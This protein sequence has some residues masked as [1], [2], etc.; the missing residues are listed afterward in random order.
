[1]DFAFLCV[2]FA[3]ATDIPIIDPQ[4]DSPQLIIE[5]RGTLDL[6]T[7]LDRLRCRQR[8]RRQ[9]T[10]KQIAFQR[11]QRCPENEICR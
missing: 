5:Q 3:Q 4:L 11:I 8:S 1:M 6:E 10:S 7:V 2:A 9:R